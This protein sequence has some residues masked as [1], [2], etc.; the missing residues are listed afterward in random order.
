MKAYSD[1]IN[2]YTEARWRVLTFAWQS[3]AVFDVG[4]D[5]FEHFGPIF[6]HRS[7]E[8]KKK[9]SKHF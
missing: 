4:S 6:C 2:V 8:G 1:M 3:S 9:A 5:T 7:A